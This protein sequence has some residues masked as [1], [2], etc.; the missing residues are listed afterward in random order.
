MYVKISILI[1]IIILYIF[2]EALPMNGEILFHWKL[3]THLMVLSLLNIITIL[4][5]LRLQRTKKVESL[6]EA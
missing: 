2:N 6:K 5:H 3:E 1:W 4:V